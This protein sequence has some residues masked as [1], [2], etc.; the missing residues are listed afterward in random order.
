[1]DPP[2]TKPT[3]FIKIQGAVP[4]HDGLELDSYA[5]NW[6]KAMTQLGLLSSKAVVIGESDDVLTGAD[7]LLVLFFGLDLSLLGIKSVLELFST[8]STWVSE[9]TVDGKVDAKYG[10]Y[11]LECEWRSLCGGDDA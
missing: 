6:L 1:M 5:K 7:L 8:V 9:V 11:L 10:Q 3:R 4:K 2:S